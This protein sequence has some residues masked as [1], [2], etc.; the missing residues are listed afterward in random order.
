MTKRHELETKHE[1]EWNKKWYFFFLQQVKKENSEKICKIEK[2]IE[3]N[4]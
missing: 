4:E 1:V 3:Q 2:H